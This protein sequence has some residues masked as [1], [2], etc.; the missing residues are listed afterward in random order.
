[1]QT[2]RGRWQVTV[3]GKHSAWDQRV[4]ITGASTGGGVIAGSVGV[5]Q[6]VD[7]DEWN[8]TI[9]HNDGSHGW[10]ENAAILPDALLENGANLSQV[11]RSKDV[12]SP[13]DTDPNDLVVR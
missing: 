7:G 9:Q 6:I 5:S 10:Q 4:V 8:L 2:Y 13:G 3:I 12:Y 11:L 1:M